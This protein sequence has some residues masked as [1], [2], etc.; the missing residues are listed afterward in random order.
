MITEAQI[1]WDESAS[2]SAFVGV[3]GR[4]R[5]AV[6]VDWDCSR[7]MGLGFG[8]A[9]AR[10]VKAMRLIDFIV[11]LMLACWCCVYILYV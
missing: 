7:G 6:L 10:P 5:A 4:K 3:G 9:E 2:E 11:M 8:A 1:F